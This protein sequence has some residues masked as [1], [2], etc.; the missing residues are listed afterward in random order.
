MMLVAL[1]SVALAA[2]TTSII[3][4]DE[5]RANVVAG[6]F[7]S[8]VALITEAGQRKGLPQVVASDRLQAQAIGMAMADHVLIGEEM[9]VARAYL[10]QDPSTTASVLTQDILRWVV[11]V[12]I[13]VL[14]ILNIFGL[15]R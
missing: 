5:V 9:F 11:I 12:A 8:E 15:V 1:D 13:G 10:E 4:D 3:A 2:G 7:G 14:V 6:S